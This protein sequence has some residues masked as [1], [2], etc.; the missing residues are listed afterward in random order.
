MW[1]YQGSPTKRAGRKRQKGLNMSTFFRIHGLK[2]YAP[3]GGGDG[4]GA[5]PAAG[6]P[7]G[8]TDAAAVQAPVAGEEAPVYKKRKADPYE[9]VRFGKQQQTE[10]T[11]P[12]PEQTAPEQKP[13]AARKPFKDIV[14]EYG[15]E[16]Q[17]YFRSSLD[18]RLK[19]YKAREDERKSIDPTLRKIARRYG[20]L[21]DDGT[22]DAKKLQAGYESDEHFV[23]EE[24]MRN[25]VSNETQKALDQEADA[26]WEAEL[27]KKELEAE[28]KQMRE[29]QDFDRWM[30]GI[31]QQEQE[32]RSIYPS[33]DFDAEMSNNRTFYTLV[34]SGASLRNAYEAANHQKL[35][36]AQ[37][38][39]VATESYSKGA[40]VAAARFR[41][42]KARP[43][44]NG[45][46]QAAS[47]G[48]ITKS[49]PRTFKLKDFE[50]IQRRVARGEKISF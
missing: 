6:T 25:G 14:K 30:N 22:I 5:A 27:Q 11:Q 46:G 20:A 37:R 21:N 42:N 33:F 3:E 8:Q 34:Q 9:N 12:A 17:D 24:A 31:R 23:E 50:E 41:D 13:E 43:V 40:Q 39:Q 49:D 48:I 18:D 44:E 36:E 38:N 2:L 47:S 10:Q 4:A 45:A 16:A 29:A 1:Q 26:R 7:G 28:L 15:K 19:G 35:M 32:V